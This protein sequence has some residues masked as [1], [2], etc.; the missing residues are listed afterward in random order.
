MRTIFRSLNENAKQ[1]KQN[2]ISYGSINIQNFNFFS[3]PQNADGCVYYLCAQIEFAGNA[4][5]IKMT[6]QK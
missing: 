1:I 3:K 5:K 6:Y 4:K 2:Y